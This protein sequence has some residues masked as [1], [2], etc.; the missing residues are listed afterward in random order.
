MKVWRTL[1]IVPL[2]TLM[3]AGPAA[4]YQDENDGTNPR[5]VIPGGMRG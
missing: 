4:A 5:V 1:A 2:A 3:L